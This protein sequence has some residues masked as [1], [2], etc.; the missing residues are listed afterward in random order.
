[1]RWLLALA[2][3]A[4]FLAASCAEGRKASP[5]DAD[6]DVEAD[7]DAAEDPEADPSGD[8]DLADEADAPD[9]ADEADAPDLPDAP[10]GDTAD[11]AAG[12]VTIVPTDPAEESPLVLVEED[13]DDLVFAVNPEFGGAARYRWFLNGDELEGEEGETLVLA[14]SAMRPGL[15]RVAVIVV[16]AEGLAHSGELSLTI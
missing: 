4:G 7:V 12:G 5:P 1:L 15:N 10:D 11:E 6:T 14:K 9:L 3:L 13:G 8:P 16:T 2:L